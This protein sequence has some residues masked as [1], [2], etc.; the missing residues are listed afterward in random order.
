M[1]GSTLLVE[2]RFASGD[3][4][5]VEALLDLDDA[6]P[7]KAFAKRWVADPKPFARDGLFRYLAAAVDRPHHRA[8]IKAIF[9]AAENN[10]E[11]VIIAHAMVA[12]DSLKV[13]NLVERVHYDWPSRTSTTSLELKRIRNIVQRA[14]DRKHA[15]T[16]TG[17]AA[18]FSAV[19]RR[20]L[21][22]RAWRY[23]R[24]LGHREPNRYRMSI[25]AALLLY[26]EHQLID[27]A[28]VLDSWGLMHALY[29]HAP[30]LTFGS[31]GVDLVEGA[32]LKT[33]EAAPFM[34]EVWQAADAFDVL[35]ELFLGAQ[36][37]PVR[38]WSVAL[39]RRFHAGPLAE[40]SIR[41]IRR[42]LESPS[43]E[44]QVLGAESLKSAKGI[45]TMSVSEW[46]S[47]LSI[48]SLEALTLI[49]AQLEV[50]VSAERLTLEECI[51][52]A[53]SKVGLVAKLG[54]AWARSKKH[55]AAQW[56]LLGRLAEAPVESIR[57]ESVAWLCQLVLINDGDS[58]KNLV[59]DLLDSKFENVRREAMALMSKDARFG[60]EPSLWSAMSESPWPDVRETLVPHLSKRASAFEPGTLHALWSATLLAIRRGTRVKRAATLQLA[61]RLVSQQ[62]EAPV[63]LPM[64]A[65]ALRSIRAPERRAA[66]GALAQACFRDPALRAQVQSAMPELEF[67]GDVTA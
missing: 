25:T 17:A 59:R 49:V 60:D 23:F 39:L 56:P 48:E 1:P 30:Q 51:S 15:A 10:S 4:R 47:L 36:S 38:S 65:L 19:T 35:F 50:H 27:V 8:L 18:R 42:L 33:L 52:L 11:D 24:K 58:L 16:A 2:E 20:Y 9:K 13:R 63:L 5:F 53:L 31:K 37:N 32:S 34:T 26:P 3:A 40:L 7:L 6:T 22:R 29:H 44:A 61:N 14:V 28:K 43:A 67:R 54:L 57:G 41:T 66:L 55:S 64:L 62:N 45:Q 21:Q 46:L 12:F